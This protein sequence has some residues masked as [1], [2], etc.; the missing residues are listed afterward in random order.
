MQFNIPIF[1]SALLATAATACNN[2]TSSTPR[3]AV[4][5]TLW[6]DITVAPNTTHVEFLPLIENNST[7]THVYLFNL[8]VKSS[9]NTLLNNVTLDYYSENG[10][11][12]NQ[13][14]ALQSKGVKVLAS[15]GGA[16]SKMWQEMEGNVSPP[17]PLFPAPFPKTLESSE[18][19]HRH[20]Y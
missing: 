5:A 11:L 6:K 15:A 14:K 9:G 16:G 8:E 19:A 18:P 12:L 13:T 20:A 3:N 10:W 4:Y 2:T 7:I 1:L 17:P